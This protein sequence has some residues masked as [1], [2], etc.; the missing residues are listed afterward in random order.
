MSISKNETTGKWDCSIWYK[1]WQ[2]KRKHTNKRGFPRKK[3]AEAFER[4]FLLKQQFLNPTMKMAA[5]KFKEELADLLKLNEIKES[6]YSNKVRIINNYILPY[7]ENKKVADIAAN[8][9][10]KWM[11]YLSANAQQR[12]R[13]SSRTLMV[14]RSILNQ[15][16]VFCQKNYNLERNPIK[17]TSRPKPF[18][19]D[20]RPK[21]WTLEE[22]QK[23]Y[24]AVTLL[25]YKV[26]FNIIFWAGLR[27]GE[28]LALTPAD[29]T[30][31]KLHIT[32]NIMLVGGNHIQKLSTPKNKHS[33]RDVEIPRYLY[34]QIQNYIALQYDIKE[35]DFLFAEITH[36]SARQ[37]LDRFAKVAKVPRITPHILRHS[38]AS[39][40]YSASHDITVVAKQIGHADINTTFRVYAHMLPEN[41]RRAVDDL[42][43]MALNKKR[44]IETRLEP[45]SD[46]RE[47]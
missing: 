19:N 2:G 17:L 34:N 16:F 20:K 24:D 39:M 30:P 10:T 9:I 47:S 13:L 28:A 22:Y 35:T 38:Y 4:D 37:K 5:E 40:L 27:I 7:F 26:L 44:Y 42:E 43:T 23:F 25:P 29:V 21:F 3:D 31:Y 18:T 36:Q 46:I 11:A 8:D 32:K 14:Y 45:D 12:E 15:I 1:D 41:D 33:I 6:T